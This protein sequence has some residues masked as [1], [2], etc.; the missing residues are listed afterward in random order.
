MPEAT[1]SIT[2]GTFGNPCTVSSVSIDDS[3]GGRVYWDTTGDQT[4]FPIKVKSRGKSQLDLKFVIKPDG[5]YTADSIAFVGASGNDPDGTGNFTNPVKDAATI[6]VTDVFAN[7]GDP[8]SP[9]NWEYSINLTKK[10]DS[11]SGKIDPEIENTNET[12]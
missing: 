1:I 6:K 4:K 5:L 3:A 8:A 7:V 12:T 9:P 11:S 10:S 2:V